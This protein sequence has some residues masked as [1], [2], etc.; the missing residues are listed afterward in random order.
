MMGLMAM[1]RWPDD[2]V[3]TS[4]IS[5]VASTAAIVHIGATPVYVDVGEDQNIDPS[6]IEEKSPKNS[7]NHASTL[8]R[9]HF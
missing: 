1:G 2:E 4:P 5:F 9:A 6:K 7:N 3:I 8:D